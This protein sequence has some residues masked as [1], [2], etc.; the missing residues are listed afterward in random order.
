MDEL[1]NL[2]LF[3]NGITGGYLKRSETGDSSTLLIQDE[4]RERFDPSSLIVLEQL[5]R[6]GESFAIIRQFVDKFMIP[7]FSR[8]DCHF[9][10]RFLSAFCHGT[11]STLLDGYR[12]VYIA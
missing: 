5:L 1:D 6:I 8:T 12:K 7:N 11:D 9:N 10:G 2:F 3:L 4:V